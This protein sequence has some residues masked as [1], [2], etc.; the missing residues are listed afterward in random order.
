M[1][2][3]DNEMLKKEVKEIKKDIENGKFTNQYITN[4]NNCGNTYNININ[5]YGHEKTDYIIPKTINIA[6]SKDTSTD[7]YIVKYVQKKHFDPDHPENYNIYMPY[8]RRDIIK[9]FI[10][11]KWENE[12]K[13]IIIPLLIEKNLYNIEEIL[14]LTENEDP[15]LYSKVL[16]KISADINNLMIGSGKFRD[17]TGFTP[18]LISNAHFE[19]RFINKMRKGVKWAN[20]PITSTTITIIST[21]IT[22]AIFITTIVI[23]TIH[24]SMITTLALYS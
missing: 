19:M 8:A 10:N 20:L 23:I 9:I 13:S 2:K 16:N 4:N 12:R 6:I 21:I 14:E 24:K 7:Q 3:K 18:F 15:I 5:D 17:I 1:L 11:G 22:T